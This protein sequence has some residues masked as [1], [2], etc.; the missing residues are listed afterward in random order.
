MYKNKN[1]ILLNF[2]GKTYNFNRVIMHYASTFWIWLG[3]VC[4]V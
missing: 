3:M 4:H 2:G 1:N